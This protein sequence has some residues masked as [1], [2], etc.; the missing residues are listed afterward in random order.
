M[1]KIVAINVILMILLLILTGCGSKKEDKS[2]QENEEEQQSEQ[3]LASEDDPEQTQESSAELSGE[4]YADV[5][6]QALKTL[7]GKGVEN[8]N[9]Y[10][11]MYYKTEFN[12]KDGEIMTCET[13]LNIETAETKTDYY[14]VD[15]D[16]EV[17]RVVLYKLL[18]GVYIYS[19]TDNFILTLPVAVAEAG[20]DIPLVPLV[21]GEPM[22]A[23]D[24]TNGIELLE[25]EGYEES[26]DAE[27][28]VYT[29]TEGNIVHTI[30][31]DKKTGLIARQTM[32]S[33]E[34]TM[35][36]YDYKYFDIDEDEFALPNDVPTME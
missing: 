14:F 22:S 27:Y 36:F 19:P 18:A 15:K 12:G 13:T 24:I 31:L 3:S 11:G 4:D 8:Q 2:E 30:W 35:E 29:H 7:I 17:T 33:D 16:G 1:K 28:V 25:F 20:A 23:E 9:Q 10:N 26:A 5:N 34:G 32:V 21:P 6:S